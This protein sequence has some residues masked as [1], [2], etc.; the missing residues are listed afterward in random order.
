MSGIES[1]EDQVMASAADAPAPVTP[2][3]LAADLQA[4]GVGPGML[5]NVHSSLSRIGWVV[6]GAQAVVEA[7][8]EVLGPDGTLM[9]PTHSGQLSD[10][11]HW[12]MPPAPESWWPTIR[13]E[14]PA[15]DPVTTPTRK[16]GAIVEVF[17]RVP[18]VERSSHPQTSHAA[19]GPLAERI[20]AEHP[21]DSFFGPRTPIGKLYELDG[22]VLLLGVDHGNN[23]VLHLAEEKAEFPGKARHHHPFLLTA[24]H[25]FHD[26]R[27]ATHRFLL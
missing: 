17:R 20:V 24:P 27:S 15:Y 2:R 13:D 4:L 12:R 1:T 9:M 25:S 22:H 26:F 3:S 19:R 7:L 11:S 6:G 23:T 21:L 18:G 14:M 5:L 16:M 10:P 8:L